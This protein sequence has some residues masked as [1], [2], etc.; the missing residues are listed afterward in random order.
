VGEMRRNVTS[1]QVALARAAP[2]LVKPGVTVK[3]LAAV[4]L[5]RADPQDPSRLIRE[6]NGN[7]VTGK[8]VDGKFKVLSDKR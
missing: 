1:G 4:P 3:T 5:F 2:K 6:I 8:F 7:K